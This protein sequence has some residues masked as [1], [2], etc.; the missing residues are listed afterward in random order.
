MA[1]LVTEGIYVASLYSFFKGMLCNIQ[2]EIIM[3]INRMC[4]SGICVLRNAW[5]MILRKLTIFYEFC[6]FCSA[7]PNWINH[8]TRLWAIFKTTHVWNC[9]SPT[10]FPMCLIDLDAISYRPSSDVKPIF[11]RNFRIPERTITK[12]AHLVSLSFIICCNTN[13]VIV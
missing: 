8:L 3:Q 5:A 9:Y 2:R 13:L 11:E 7:Q 1:P 4:H 12:M 10:Y 6:T